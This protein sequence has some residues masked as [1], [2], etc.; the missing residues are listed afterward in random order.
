MVAAV[1][2]YKGSMSRRR[3]SFCLSV[4]FTQKK[5]FINKIL[6]VNA[7]MDIDVDAYIYKK[8]G[9]GLRSTAAICNDAFQPQ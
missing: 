3:D 5:G 6:T 1:C 2:L 4:S 7:H 9:L 8:I